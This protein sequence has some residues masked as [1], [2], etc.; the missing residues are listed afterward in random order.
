[1]VYLQNINFIFMEATL[2]FP[3]L[4]IMSLDII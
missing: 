3:Y 4:D 1:M 2:A